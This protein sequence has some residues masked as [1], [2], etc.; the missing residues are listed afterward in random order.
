M[1][2]EMMERIQKKTNELLQQIE[3]LE[4]EKRTKE[5]EQVITN[6]LATQTPLEQMVQSAKGEV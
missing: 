3:E 2:M 6:M 5:I 4:K 1:S